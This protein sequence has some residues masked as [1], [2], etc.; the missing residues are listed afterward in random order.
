[1][2]SACVNVTTTATIG[3]LG[4]PPRIVPNQAAPNLTVIDTAAGQHCVAPDG[5]D[6]QQTTLTWN[7]TGP[8]GATGAAGQNGQNGRS[9]TVVSGHTLTL[10]GGNVL[11]VGGGT[12]PTF[13]IN[14]PPETPSGKTLTLSLGSTPIEILGYGFG[15]TNGLGGG[16]GSGK[17]A[18]H[19]ISI[20]KK[21]DVASPKLAQACVTG[22]HFPTATITVRKAGKGQQ[23]YLKITLK[24]VLIS[25]FQTGG[26]GPNKTPTES[27][28]LNFTKIDFKYTRQK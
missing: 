3:T 2:I 24:D 18:V 6:T 23:A 26:S 17:V 11:G 19:D 9:V 12:G 13:T 10:P 25:S 28:T 27:L 8:T 1:V 7:A 4:S 5:T 15:T 22:K 21:M 14:S 16:G 20:T